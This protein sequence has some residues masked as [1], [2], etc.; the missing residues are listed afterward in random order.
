[1]PQP[2][3]ISGMS[4]SHPARSG[5][6]QQPLFHQ[7]N[8][9]P[10]SNCMPSPAGMQTSHHAS[11][12]CLPTITSLTS[13]AG[14]RRH[15]G[16]CALVRRLGISTRRNQH[17]TASTEPLPSHRSLCCASCP[18]ID[19]LSSAVCH[20][21]SCEP[22]WHPPCPLSSRHASS[23][24]LTSSQLHTCSSLAGEHACVQ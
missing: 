13:A 5:S 12:L 23:S 9:T 24:Q 15:L 21:V 10:H 11:P 7:A 3:P 1:M 14:I 8:T 22:L 20:R 4:V 6:S 17:T 16:G 19:A 2:H 18:E